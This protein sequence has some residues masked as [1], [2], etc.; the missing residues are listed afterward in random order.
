M[1]GLYNFLFLTLFV[2]NKLHRMKERLHQRWK[3]FRAMPHAMQMQRMTRAARDE[4]SRF[5]NHQS[6][7]SG[8]PTNSAGFSQ[9]ASAT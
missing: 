9:K 8:A 1:K 6:P 5:H 2:R 4:I 7:T 3:I